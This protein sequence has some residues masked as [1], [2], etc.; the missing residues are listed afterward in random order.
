M[1]HHYV[2]NEHRMCFFFYVIFFIQ[3]CY[4][5][6]VFLCERARWP[7]MTVALVFHIFCSVSHMSAM[8]LRHRIKNF[9]FYTQRT[10]QKT[11]EPGQALQALVYSSKLA[12]QLLYLTET[13]QRRHSGCACLFVF[14]IPE[15]FCLS[16]QTQR[17]ILCE[18]PL[19]FH[20]LPS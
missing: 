8:F 7:C 14:Y 6:I 11:P 3:I 16:F 13:E 19:S 10:N 5:S 15:C 20:L 9:N 17:C 1:T 4:F 18:R 12:W 2:Q